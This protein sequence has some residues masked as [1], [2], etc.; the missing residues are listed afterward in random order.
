[1]FSKMGRRLTYGNIAMTLALLFA[2]SGGAYA[3]SKYVITSTK[4]ISPK[5]LNTLKG[6]NGKTGATGSAGAVG[7]VGPAG[8]I[9]PAGKDGAAGANG[10]NGTNGANGENVTSTALTTKNTH[11]EEG[12]SEFTVAGKHTYA[13]NGSP[14]VTGTLPV[15]K[16]ET[17]QWA[18]SQYMPKTGGD[19]FLDTGLSFPIPLAKALDEEQVHYIG[20]GEGENE[21]ESKWALA[22]KEHECKGSY[23]K[24]EAASGSLC[25]FTAHS[26]NWGVDS[27]VLEPVVFSIKNEE[28]GAEGAGV[29]GAVLTNNG[30]PAKQ[31]GSVTMTGDWVVTG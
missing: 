6:Q 10:S 30:A 20:L 21:E 11:C 1:M 18:I 12:G 22:I 29:S 14:W 7:P 13:C 27:P 2:M 15:G 25:V 3:A 9:G 31:A 8:P 19:E 28:A 24:P 23:E 5:V 17:G 4:Q 16:H 26:V